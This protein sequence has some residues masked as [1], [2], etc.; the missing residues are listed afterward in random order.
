ML[1]SLCDRRSGS[2]FV[3]L[4][5]WGNCD[6]SRIRQASPFERYR[7]CE[8]Y[9]R[10][11]QTCPS[12]IA[13]PSLATCKIRTAVYRAG[14]RVPRSW[15][16]SSSLCMGPRSR[17]TDKMPKGTAATF[18][19]LEDYSVKAALDPEPL[20]K[21]REEERKQFNISVLYKRVRWGEL[22]SVMALHS[23]NVLVQEM[24]SLAEHADMLRLRFKTTMA[25]H[26]MRRARK[27]KLYPLATSNLNEG[28]AGENMNIL[29][30]LL[31]FQLGRPPDEV[32]NCSSSWAQSAVEKLRI[33]VG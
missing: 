18:V 25:M 8:S 15:A 12:W 14:F 31:V 32:E 7:I 10:N 26:R 16:R 19:G 11:A 27:T 17:Q 9:A 33:L 6:R 28:N 29:Y 5:Q 13:A 23:L 30:D 2:I 21:A 22:E 4:D 1:S 20:Q 3:T 24:P